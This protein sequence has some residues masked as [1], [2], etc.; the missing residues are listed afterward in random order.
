MAFGLSFSLRD[1]YLEK[2][3]LVVGLGGNWHD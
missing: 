3:R 2:I 1:L